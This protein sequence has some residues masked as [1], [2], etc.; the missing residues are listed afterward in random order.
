MLRNLSC[1]FRCLFIFAA[2]LIGACDNLIFNALETSGYFEINNQKAERQLFD[3]VYLQFEQFE[4]FLTQNTDW[5]DKL[6]EIDKEYE[7]FS[8][9]EIYGYPFL[10]SKKQNQYT[11][12]F[13]ITKEYIRFLYNQY[14]SFIEQCSEFS[15]LLNSLQTIEKFSQEI[16]E[17]T[18]QR[19]DPTDRLYLHLPDGDLAII[20]LLIK[21][22]PSEEIASRPHFDR[23]AFT[24]MLDNSEEYEMESLLI[25]P[26]NSDYYATDF[27]R[28]ARQY[29][30]TN[31]SSSCLFVPGFTPKYVGFPIEPTPHAVNQIKQTRYAAIA[32]VMI[33]YVQVFAFPITKFQHDL[34]QLYK[35][36][37]P[38][39]LR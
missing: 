8:D 26:Y 38:E 25:A 19:I 12:K 16:F 15:N 4:Q 37:I 5:K 31:D 17:D 1:R 13:A 20:V 33:P 14:P 3:K 36:P 32:F 29:T 9:N 7:K 21:Y 23:S 27:S 11:N 6:T 30:K 2:P 18:I 22:E 39:D 24:L 10:G 34:F 35:V 28:P